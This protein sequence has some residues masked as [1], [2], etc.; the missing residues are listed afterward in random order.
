MAGREGS[1]PEPPARVGRL[2]LRAQSP[3]TTASN[4]PSA[5]PTNWLQRLLGEN[6]EGSE[7][8]PEVFE[9]WLAS[10]RTNAADLLAARQAGGGVD[11]LRRA[12]TNFPNDPRVLFAASALDDGPEARRERL[13]RFKAAAPD[14][15]LA[16]YLSAR[17]HFQTSWKGA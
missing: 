7:L 1:E 5:T 9:Q 17:D 12:L 13:D 2:A 10:G 4:T 16:D 8:P 6:G 3:D 15:A 14:N 11:Y